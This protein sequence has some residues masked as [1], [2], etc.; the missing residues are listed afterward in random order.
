[1][2]VGDRNHDLRLGGG[3][4]VSSAGSNPGQSV[5]GGSIGR[6]R[7]DGTAQTRAELDGRCTLPGFRRRRGRRGSMGVRRWRR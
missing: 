5:H 7:R 2:V 6:T 3:G 1:M 4:V